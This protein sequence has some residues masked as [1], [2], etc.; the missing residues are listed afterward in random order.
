M[1]IFSVLAA[2]V[3]FFGLLTAWMLNGAPLPGLAPPKR[4]APEGFDAADYP[5]LQDVRPIGMASIHVLNDF[6]KPLTHSF[7]KDLG[8]IAFRQIAQDYTWRTAFIDARG[9]LIEV[10]T[11]ASQG[12]PLGPFS[13][14]PDSYSEVMPDD[15]TAPQ[16]LIEVDAS[17][18]G[19]LKRMLDESE[20]YRRYSY[21]N[22]PSDHPE[23]NTGRIVHVFYHQNVWKRAV[24]S[25]DKGFRDWSLTSGDKL[26]FQRGIHRIVENNVNPDVFGDRYRVELTHFE[27]E[28]YFSS[29]GA[30][31]GS[32]TGGGSSAHWL[33]T[34]YYTVFVDD[35]PVLKFRIYGDRDYLFSPGGTHTR[36]FIEGDPSLDLILLHQYGGK[37]GEVKVV[38]AATDPS[39]P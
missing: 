13:I 27:Q 31:L 15:V 25:G 7:R 32:K 28:H 24:T 11:D 39:R 36:L 19:E 1:K 21:H 12:T 14:D 3:L 34:G 26:H 4:P 33:G 30:G 22:L 10:A 9:R 6:G 5:E 23:K 20:Y 17:D 37:L 29:R 16:P 8:I 18:I 35:A 2:S 38:V